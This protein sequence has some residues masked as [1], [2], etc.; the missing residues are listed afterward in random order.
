MIP[1]LWCIKDIIPDIKEMVLQRCIFPA[2]KK[3]LLFVDLILWDLLQNSMGLKIGVE[4]LIKHDVNAVCGHISI[5][6][7]TLF[8][9][10]HALD[11]SDAC[12]M[13]GAS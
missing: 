3:Y 2:N 9:L 1:P 12:N 4:A 8:P 7:T 13:F 6:C 5:L 11:S 10:V